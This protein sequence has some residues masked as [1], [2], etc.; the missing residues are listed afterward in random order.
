MNFLM[1]FLVG[2]RFVLLGW[3]LKS[4]QRFGQPDQSVDIERDEV[5]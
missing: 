1:N 2:M 5:F 4:T 3:N